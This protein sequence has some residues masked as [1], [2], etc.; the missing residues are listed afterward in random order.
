MRETWSVTALR[1]GSSIDLILDATGDES[2]ESRI[3]VDVAKSS[4]RLVAKAYR[5]SKVVF[6]AEVERPSAKSVSIFVPRRRLKGPFRWHLVTT[7]SGKS[8]PCGT[9]G[10]VSLEC[11]DRAPD[12]G[13]LR[14]D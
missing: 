2:F 6:R 5:G 11:F 14:H 13:S 9:D 1:R 7:Y 10:D 4:D 3:I 12:Q 8:G